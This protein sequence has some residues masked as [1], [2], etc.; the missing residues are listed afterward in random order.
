[1][2]KRRKRRFVKSRPQLAVDLMTDYARPK[3]NPVGGR[4]LPSAMKSGPVA[5]PA[6]TQR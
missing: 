4:I 2:V 6:A 5:K 3:R 1:M